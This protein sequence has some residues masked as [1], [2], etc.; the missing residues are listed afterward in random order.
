[1]FVHTRGTGFPWWEARGEGCQQRGDFKDL[2][3]APYL[4]LPLQDGLRC[5]PGSWQNMAVLA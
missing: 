1:M 3:W 2:F 4:G 5:Q